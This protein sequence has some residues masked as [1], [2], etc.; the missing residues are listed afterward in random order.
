MIKPSIRT[1]KKKCLA[2]KKDHEFIYKN[3]YHQARTKYCPDCA[4][5]NLKKKQKE[6]T[7]LRRLNAKNEL[8][9]SVCYTPECNKKSHKVYINS[10]DK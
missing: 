4:M 10:L 3:G 8:V 6:R 9:E 2:C 5:S 1:F 7:K